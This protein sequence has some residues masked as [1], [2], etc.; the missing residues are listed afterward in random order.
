VDRRARRPPRHRP[1]APAAPPGNPRRDAPHRPAGRRA[2][3]TADRERAERGRAAGR[4]ACAAR[5][6]R[7]GDR[8][9]AAHRGIAL[10]PAVP[11]AD[12]RN[13]AAAMAP[14]LGLFLLPACEAAARY[15]PGVRRHAAREPVLRAPRDTPGL[16]L[17]APCRRRTVCD[18]PTPGQ[19][20]QAV[21]TN[22]RP[23][24]RVDRATA[25]RPRQ[26]RPPRYGRRAPRRS[27]DGRAVADAPA[28]EGW[29]AEDRYAA[30]RRARA[31]HASPA[32][33]RRAAD[34]RDSQPSPPGDGRRRTRGDRTRVRGAAPQP[35]RGAHPAAGYVP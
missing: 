20:R 30:A 23:H 4:D 1:G 8:R 14:G 35:E 6:R 22:A 9:M 7:A 15:L 2:D 17:P 34:G 33:S 26:S 31:G 12:R 32:A 25:G 21:D 27:A 5:A 18:G 10:L 29:R 19:A 11:G 13:L 28:R 16:L 3:A 24:R